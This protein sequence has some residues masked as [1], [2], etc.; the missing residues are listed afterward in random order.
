MQ[1]IIIRRE[2][3]Q[4][5]TWKIMLMAVVLALVAAGWAQAD[6]ATSTLTIN[7][8]INAKAKLSLS[9]A[10]I[11]FDDSGKDPDTDKTI[12]SDKPV[13]IT[14]KVKT[15]S[16]TGATLTCLASGDFDPAIPVSAVTWTSG[17]TNYAPTGTMDKT[18]AQNVASRTG[19]GDLSGTITPLMATSWNYPTGN[20][21]VTVTY[22]LT[23]P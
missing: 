4:M 11:T 18:T 8:K 12:S 23:A 21:S 7:A 1:K 15:G 22:T 20:Y 16:S 5:K 2:S 6:T 9:P 3:K 14:A 19:S 13:D 10:T 17:S